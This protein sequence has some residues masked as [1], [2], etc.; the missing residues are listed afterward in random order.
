MKPRILP[1]GEILGPLISSLLKKE[2]IEQLFYRDYSTSSK[3]W[4]ARQKKDVFSRE[5]KVQQ[6]KSRAA[7]KLLEVVHS[8]WSAANRS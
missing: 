8:L 4:V 1:S 2:C 3:R 7:F 5:A 6:Y